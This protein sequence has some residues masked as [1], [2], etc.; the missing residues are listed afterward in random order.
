MRELPPGQ[1]SPDV[2]LL[3]DQ[4]IV[5]AG[6]ARLLSQAGGFVVAE[7]G[8]VDAAQ[9]VIR[10]RSPRVVVLGLAAPPSM[11]FEAVRRIREVSDKVRI[12]VLSDSEDDVFARRAMKVGANGFV[13]KRIAPEELIEALR[14]LMKGQNYLSTDI[15]RRIA[16]SALTDDIDPVEALSNREFEIFERLARG[17]TVAEIAGKLNLSSKTVANHR[18]AVLKKLGV[19]NTVELAHLSF[20]RGLPGDTE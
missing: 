20:R 6:I 5:R 1:R 18:L 8:S 17:E 10:A 19:K 2:L 12:L 13:S 15:A 9:T 16:N 3:D 11:G 4:R 7:A 14:L